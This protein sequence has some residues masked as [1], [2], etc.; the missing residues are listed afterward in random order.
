MENIFIFQMF[1]PSP[2]IEII[3]EHCFPKE[4]I[5]MLFV[6]CTICTIWYHFYYLKNMR[7]TLE[8]CYF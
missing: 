6:I 8:E 1:L 7:N 3:N 5:V 2:I 4:L